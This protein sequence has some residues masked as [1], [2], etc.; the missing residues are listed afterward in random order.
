MHRTA[1]A[2]ITS[3][4]GGEF[5]TLVYTTDV[6]DGEHLVLVKG[7]IRPDEPTL[8]RPHVEYMP[9]DVFGYRE[10]DTRS[11]L[12]R[13]MERIA[14]EGRGVV[15]YLRRERRGLDLFTPAAAEGGSGPST[16]LP[17]RLSTFRDFGI[18]AQ[19]LRDIGVGKIRWLTNNPLRLASL[20]GYGLQ[21]VESVPLTLEE[22]DA[23]PPAPSATTGKVL[24][25]R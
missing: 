24:R 10:R 2:R 14:A 11:L 25:L 7:D 18:G 8:V 20:P 16:S 1:E 5:R 13:A 23:P 19:I 17:S 4:Y 3:R 22:A 6:D 15:L 9:G 12:H 21:I